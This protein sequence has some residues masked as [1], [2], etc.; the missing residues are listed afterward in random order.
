MKG[1]IQT[2]VSLKYLSLTKNLGIIKMN[3]LEF[4]PLQEFEEL[5]WLTRS[6]NYTSKLLTWKFFYYKSRKSHKISTR[7]TQN[8]VQPFKHYAMSLVTTIQIIKHPKVKITVHEIHN[9]RHLQKSNL[10]KNHSVNKFFRTK[11]ESVTHNLY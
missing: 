10:T 5:S 1:L 6:I 7:I 11:N 2:D 9:L 4:V 3:V 8:K